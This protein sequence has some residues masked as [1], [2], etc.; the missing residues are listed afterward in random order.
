VLLLEFT[1]RCENF[2]NYSI[3]DNRTCGY[4]DQDYLLEELIEMPRQ[5]V[6]LSIHW[7]LFWNITCFFELN[8]STFE[9]V[10]KQNPKFQ[11]ISI[12]LT[13]AT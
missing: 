7:I 12:L 3:D 1:Q 8:L 10:R 13:V 2:S 5:A 11:E 9:I 4:S 6:V